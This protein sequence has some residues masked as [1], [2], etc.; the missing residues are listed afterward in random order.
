MRRESRT[1][2]SPDEPGRSVRFAS[3]CEVDTVSTRSRLCLAVASLLISASQ[4]ASAQTWPTRPVTLVVPFSA[5][6]STDILARRVA[7]DLSE[8]LGQQF[9]VEN[10]GGANGNTGAG[11]VANAAPDGYTIL[12]ATPGPVATNKFLYT[13]LSFDPDR[14]FVPIVL[15]GESPLVIVATPRLPVKTLPELMARASSNPG[16]VNVGTPGVGSQAHLTMLLLEKLSGTTMTYVPYRGGSNVSSDLLGGQIEVGVNYLPSFIG[17][18]SN[19]SLRGLA[20]T[21]T[22]RS[23]ELPD[24]PTVQESGFPG[25]ESTAWYALMAPAGTPAA[26]IENL[27]RAVNAYIASASGKKQLHELSMQGTGGTPDD[28]RSHIASEIKTWEPVIK[29]ANIQM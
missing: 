25:F 3:T 29:A 22:K 15:I 21:S 10:R 4:L 17:A 12:F 14:A 20:V 26:V 23:Q 1:K 2:L 5:G 28:L 7:N 16:K 8:Q 27:N 11:L 6:G 19:G 24:V 9:V 18:I 13:N